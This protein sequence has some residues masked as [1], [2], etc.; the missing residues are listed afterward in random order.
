MCSVLISH[1]SCFFAGKNLTNFSFS[2]FCSFFGGK[3]KKPP[4]VLIRHGQTRRLKMKG[5]ELSINSIILCCTNWV[6]MYFGF[7]YLLNRPA[8]GSLFHIT[9]LHIKIRILYTIFLLFFSFFE[10]IFW[11]KSF[12]KRDFLLKKDLFFYP[13]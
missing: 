11:K 13:S 5:C 1:K 8:L 4:C 9:I 10:K 3:K 7:G 12:S 2:R 6:F